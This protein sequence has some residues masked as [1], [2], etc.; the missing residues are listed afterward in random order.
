MWEFVELR[1]IRVFLVL[2]EELHFGRTAERLRLSQ[3]RVSQTIQE[4]ETKLGAPLFER[5]SR[6]VA[7]TSA[8]QRLYER[9]VPLYR[10]LQQT[11]RDVHE[12]SH[13]VVGKLRLG[14]A[15]PSAAGQSFPEIV[16][17]FE[18]RHP[19]C[20]VEV[21]EVALQ[22]T[23]APLRRREV[24][25][26]ALNLPIE[27]PD[28]TIGPV[29]RRDQRVIAVAADHPL[30]CR[31]SVSIEDIADFETHDHGGGLPSES[32]DAWSPP[33]TPAGRPIRRRHLAAPTFSQ[34]FA[35]VAAGEIVHFATTPV[36]LTFP[37]IVYVPI[38]DMPPTES[39]LAWLTDEE[40]S[41]IRAFADAAATTNK[42]T[43]P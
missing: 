36:F 8:G 12:A 1:E 18:S 22:D 29:L 15:G 10:D 17:L 40:T 28:I 37:G 16:K 14:L 26:L 4:L 30:A 23:L 31:E 13:G 5:T 32:L 3:T 25:L 7:I 20:S 34:V 2:C 35:L 19:G 43:P 27:Q 41:A 21:S 11:L 6:R 24:D 42:K 33:T 9:A 38:R 39:A